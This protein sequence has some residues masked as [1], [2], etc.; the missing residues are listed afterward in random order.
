MKTKRV[1]S[2]TLFCFSIIVRTTSHSALNALSQI[3]LNR[4]GESRTKIANTWSYFRLERETMDVEPEYRVRKTSHSILNA[5]SQI[6]LNRLGVS[7]QLNQNQPLLHPSSWQ[8]QNLGSFHQQQNQC[9][10]SQQFSR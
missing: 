8:R 6:L 7:P 10:A 4:L 1:S 3:L 2:D 5:L 9:R